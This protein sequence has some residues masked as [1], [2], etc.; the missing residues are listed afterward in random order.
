MVGVAGKGRAAAAPGPPVDINL[1]KMLLSYVNSLA[2]VGSWACAWAYSRDEGARE[3]RGHEHRREK[4]AFSPVRSAT[5]ANLISDSNA[6][7]P[8]DGNSR[9]ARVISRLTGLFASRLAINHAALQP[10]GRHPRKYRNKTKRE[11]ALRIG[12][13]IARDSGPRLVADKGW[14]TR[15]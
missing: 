8:K 13:G 14:R 1:D 6:A 7:D 12:R 4:S 9:G 3:A 10:R 5:A 2:F 11:Q 15:A